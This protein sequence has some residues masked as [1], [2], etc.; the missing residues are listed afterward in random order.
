MNTGIKKMF[1]LIYFSNRTIVLKI[2]YASFFIFFGFILIFYSLSFK[3][4][5]NHYETQLINGNY[6]RYFQKYDDPIYNSPL[7]LYRT[8]DLDQQ[9]QYPKLRSFYRNG[10]SQEKD[11]FG[12]I[13]PQKL[14]SWS[15]NYSMLNYFQPETSNSDLYN[16]YFIQLEDE[17]YLPTLISNP[18]N[19]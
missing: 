13:M 6:Y 18:N 9:N 12:Q 8:Y 2:I 14:L 11:N 7:S 16:R 15:Q 19:L 10:Y 4:N 17:N 5:Y 3:S 1:S